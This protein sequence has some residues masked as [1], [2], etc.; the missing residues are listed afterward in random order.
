MRAIFLALLF[1]MLAGA[2]QAQD[3]K[4]GPCDD[5]VAAGG[6]I[7][8][9]P[10]SPGGGAFV[11]SCAA[12]GAF[13][14]RVSGFTLASKQ[15]YDFLICG[16]DANGIGC[17]DRLDAL[18]VLAAPNVNAWRL[19]LCGTSGTLTQTS[20]TWTAN[21]GWTGNGTTGFLTTGV[22]PTTYARYTLNSASIGGCI[23]ASRT[24]DNTGNMIGADNT[25]GE[26]FIQPKTNPSSIRS[27]LNG[28]VGTSVLVGGIP[29]A[30]R[31]WHLSRT[32]GANAFIYHEGTQAFQ[33]PIT[34]V[35][36]PNVPFY[37][38][39]TNIGGTAMHFSTDQIAVVFIGGGMSSSEVTAFYIIWQTFIGQAKINACP[40]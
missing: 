32:D 12:S 1:T 20:G 39:A 2:A 10:C 15:A 6:R 16:L 9:H 26:S 11:P 31:F 5:T 17:T 37:I 40:F 33:M 13:L 28:A 8:V 23:S 35:D 30:S 4:I 24:T 3:I 36:V 38:G 22:N 25:V 21:V 27:T 18:Y 19:N 29:D 34:A 14:A 7:S